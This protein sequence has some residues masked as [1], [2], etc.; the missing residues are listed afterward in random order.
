[1]DGGISEFCEYLSHG[2]AV[3]GVLRLQ[4]ADTFTETVPL[5]DE[6]GHMTPQ[7]VERELLVDVAVRWDTGYETEVRSFVNVIATPKGGTHV[8][9]FEAALTRTFNDAMR[10]SRVLRVNDADVVKDDILEGL[11]AV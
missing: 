2:E 1:H 6:Q 5:L 7:D 8:A 9:G 4:G 3:T 10:A 11:T